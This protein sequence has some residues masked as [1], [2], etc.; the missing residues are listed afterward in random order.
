MRVAVISM[1]LYRRIFVLQWLLPLLSMLSPVGTL[2]AVYAFISKGY[3]GWTMGS[4]ALVAFY[5][6]RSPGPE[7]CAIYRL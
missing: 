4:L 3:S 5:F 2:A 1:L 6:G 7:A